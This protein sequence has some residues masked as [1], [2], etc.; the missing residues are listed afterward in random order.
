[1][2]ELTHKKVRCAEGF[3]YGDLVLFSNTYRLVALPARDEF[4]E[5][6][7][8]VLMTVPERLLALLQRL[9]PPVIPPLC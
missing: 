5:R 6:G 9:Q 4:Y 8:Q 3:T 7:S 1:M 2:Q